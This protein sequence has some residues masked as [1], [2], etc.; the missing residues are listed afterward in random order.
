MMCANWILYVFFSLLSASDTMS[1]SVQNAYLKCMKF[2]KK[3][4]CIGSIFCF[5]IFIRLMKNYQ[6]AKET[7]FDPL[8]SRRGRGDKG[9]LILWFVFFFLLP[10]SLLSSQQGLSQ[11]IAVCILAL[12]E[13]LVSSSMK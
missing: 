13:L 8:L 4:K 6:K 10:H 2:P 3:L 11:Q 9:V 5:A 12:N 1:Y 7:G